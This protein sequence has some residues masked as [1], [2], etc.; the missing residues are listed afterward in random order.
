MKP[1]EFSIKIHF[2]FIPKHTA[3]HMEKKVGS[4]CAVKIQKNIFVG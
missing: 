2:D 3:G 4:K 1:A